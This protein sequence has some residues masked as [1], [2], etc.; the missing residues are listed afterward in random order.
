MTREIIKRVAVGLPEDWIYFE[1]TD[2]ALKY[3]AEICNKSAEFI[4][5]NLQYKCFQLLYRE[6]KNDPDLNLD[7][8][9]LLAFQIQFNRECIQ[10]IHRLVEN[11]KPSMFK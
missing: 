1:G 9:A 6:R 8:L 5:L 10:E 7:E 4:H 3:A 11:M 2:H